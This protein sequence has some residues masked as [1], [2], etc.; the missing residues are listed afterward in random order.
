MKD[1]KGIYLIYIVDLEIYQF[2]FNFMLFSDFLSLYFITHSQVQA[3]ASNK[4]DSIANESDFKSFYTGPCLECIATDLD[5][6]S[7]LYFRVRAE[8]GQHSSQW[9]ASLSVLMED[10]RFPDLQS[11]QLRRDPEFPARLQHRITSDWTSPVVKTS[12]PRRQTT[13]STAVNSPDFAIDSAVSP[14]DAQWRKVSHGMC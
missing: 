3:S 2:K 5:P 8:S 11:P 9:S 13:P 6:Q 4:E 12:S 14:S 1:D 10:K 7:K